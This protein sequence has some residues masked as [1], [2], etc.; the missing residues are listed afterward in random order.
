M[1]MDIPVK[2]D[3]QRFEIF[4]SARCIGQKHYSVKLPYITFSTSDGTS[5]NTT[6]Q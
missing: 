5:E 3:S 6:G 2:K 1:Q 4:A